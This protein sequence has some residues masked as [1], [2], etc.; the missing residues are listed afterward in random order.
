[1]VA[2]RL[3]RALRA[4]AIPILSVSVGSEADRA[5][6]AIQYD[7]SATAQHRTDGEALR[8]TFDPLSQAAI[9][10]EKAA[11]AAAIDANPLIQA[12][13]QLDFEERQKLVVINGQTLRTA[14]QCKARVRAIYQSLL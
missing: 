11:F 4:A 2:E 3:D 13:A 8:Q 14:A 6:W 1:M 9:D 10:A 7:P 12:V 5:T